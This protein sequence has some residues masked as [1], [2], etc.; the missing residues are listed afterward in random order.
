MNPA[1]SETNEPINI[2]PM[3]KDEARS[4]VVAIRSN[5]ESL[6]A[7]L[8]DLERRRGWEALGYSS[9]RECAIA[10][11]GKSQGYV[12]KLLHAAEVDENLAA[13]EIY[14]MDKSEIALI[15]TSH[16]EELH[17]LPFDQQA[18]A[19]QKADALAIAEGKSREVK[20]VR[21]VVKEYKSVAAQIKAK[22]ESLGLPTQGDS[23]LP[24][25]DRVDDLTHV[26][27]ADVDDRPGVL[28]LTP[29]EA[30]KNSAIRGIQGYL[31]GMG[32]TAAAQA[33]TVVAT[34]TPG[35]EQHVDAVA[36]RFPRHDR[37]ALRPAIIKGFWEMAQSQ[38]KKTSQSVEVILSAQSEDEYSP[39]TGRAEFEDEPETQA[40]AFVPTAAQWRAA[41][42]K[43]VELLEALRDAQ[44]ENE[45][46]TAE[47]LKLREANGNLHNE[48]AQLKATLAAVK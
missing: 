45:Q 1:T 28:P 27:P 44:V 6:G 21:Q 29:S 3:T 19:L 16:K 37:V 14:P 10:E 20:H 17:K 12:Y 48:I 22:G 24:A 5:L 36:N 11:F 23:V 40:P 39:D 18:E 33:L 42:A 15:P 34:Q 38:G 31:S 4:C 9:F 13:N 2:T 43:R 7:M 25:S 47:N 32:E 46:L 8:L 30:L 26:S 41:Q 35:W